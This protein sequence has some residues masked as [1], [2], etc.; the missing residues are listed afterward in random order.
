[1]NAYPN[2]IPT[3]VYAK[4]TICQIGTDMARP[5]TVGMDAM[6]K[7][8][9]ATLERICTERFEGNQSALARAIGRSPTIV[10]RLLEHGENQKGMGERLARA[11]EKKLG[12]A[13]FYLDGR[14][15]GLHQGATVSSDVA[16]ALVD[17]RAVPLLTF[18]EVARVGA[19]A[20]SQG[21]RV[22]IVFGARD[23]GA[24]AFG[25][26]VT[27]NAMSPE[28]VEGDRII[29]DPEVRPTAGDVVIAKVQGGGTVFRR[30]RPRDDGSTFELS[31]SNENYA[32][33][34]SDRV[35]VELIATMVEHHRYRRR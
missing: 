6:N 11:I 34:W 22:G 17:S 15:Q 1:M 2:S 19:S 20:A 7:K 27:G 28:F 5:Y 24:L 32:P 8:R 23:L 14:A 3:G 13:E 30:Y 26:V 12:L 4:H 18:D 9:R 29:V 10:W 16:A 31:A 33:V 35:K 25:L 21:E